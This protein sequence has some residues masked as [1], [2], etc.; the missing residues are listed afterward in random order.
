MWLSYSRCGEIV[1]VKW[2]SCAYSN[3]D[4]V[5]IN[6]VKQCEKDLTWWSHNVFG[7]IRKELNRKKKLLIEEEAMAVRSGDNTWV[8]SLKLEI[9]TLLDHEIRMWK[10]QSWILWLSN[11]DG[12]IKYFHTRASHCFKRNSLV[13]I[14]NS[15]NVWTENMEEIPEVLTSHRFLSRSLYHLQSEPPKLR[16]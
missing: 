9:N 16:P 6:K 5:V 11:G 1:E 4:R 10:Q 7:N 14:Y 15:A 8:R 2:N 12:N 13:G 3:P